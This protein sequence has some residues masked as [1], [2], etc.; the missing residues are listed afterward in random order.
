MAV[1]KNEFK[2]VVYQEISKTLPACSDP[3]RL[4]ILELLAQCKRNVETLASMLGAGITTTSH[5]LQLLKQ[6]RLVRTHKVGRYVLLLGD[7]NSSLPLEQLLRAR[8]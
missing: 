2:Q 6:A 1:N 7:G 4:E 3:R 8:L 5:H